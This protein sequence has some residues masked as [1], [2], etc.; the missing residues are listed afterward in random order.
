MTKLH[1]ADIDFPSRESVRDE[2][3]LL[4]YSMGGNLYQLRSADTYAPLADRFNID[5]EAKKIIQDEI[6]KNGR[7]EPVWNNMVQWARQDLVDGG[8]LDAHTPRSVWR[9]TPKG[10]SHAQLILK[11]R[12]SVQDSLAQWRAKIQIASESKKAYLQDQS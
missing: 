4:I 8:Y 5:S 9:L 3:A 6:Y 11:T 10:V 1:G 2:L 12:K 7:A